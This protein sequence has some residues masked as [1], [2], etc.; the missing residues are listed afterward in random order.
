MDEISVKGKQYVK[1]KVLARELGYTNDYIGQLCRAGKVD[2]ELVGRTWYVDPDSVR[3]HKSTR[4]RSTKATT[5]KGVQA[6]VLRTL[7]EVVHIKPNFYT[8]HHTK[9]FAKQFTYETDE[10]ELVPT[11]SKE[12]HAKKTVLPVELADAR[13]LNVA[14][15][16]QKQY[17]FAAPEREETKFFGTLRVTDFLT[18]LSVEGVDDHAHTVPVKGKVSAVVAEKTPILKG[19]KPEHAADTFKLKQP[20]PLMKPKPEFGK[21]QAPALVAVTGDEEEVVS[22]PIMYRVAVV[23]AFIIALVVATASVGLEASV[24]AQNEGTDIEYVFTVKNLSALLF[25]LK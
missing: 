19:H 2:A 14:V 17:H 11:A 13:K 25:E 6:E 8:P 4:Y 3:G 18:E 9:S 15:E 22:L 12:R 5:K 10:T 16:N 23:A 7:Q 21:S 20:G 1:A 24:T